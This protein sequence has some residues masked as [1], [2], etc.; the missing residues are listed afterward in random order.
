[1][2][3][4]LGAHATLDVEFMVESVDRFDLSEK[5]F[6][7][8]KSRHAELLLNELQKLTVSGA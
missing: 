3:P 2:L 8:R 4:E 1:M 6:E 5:R 7:G